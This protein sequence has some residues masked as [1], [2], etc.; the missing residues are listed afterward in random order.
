MEEGR[1]GLSFTKLRF[2]PE[3]GGEGAQ[4]PQVV[5]TFSLRCSQ[6]GFMFTRGIE[7]IPLGSAGW[8]AP[9]QDNVC[10]VG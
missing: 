6:A 9:A 3:E 5:R 7:K 2:G 10:L 8:G 4:S 1:Q